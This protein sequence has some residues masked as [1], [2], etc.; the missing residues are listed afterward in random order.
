[1]KPIDDDRPTAA[2]RDPLGSHRHA[3]HTL[4]TT[5]FRAHDQ[6]WHRGEAPR[7]A[8][9]VR[10]PLRSLETTRVYKGLCK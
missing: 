2:S 5:P 9:R 6:C 10:L 7:D 4:A 8:G 1:L 3:T